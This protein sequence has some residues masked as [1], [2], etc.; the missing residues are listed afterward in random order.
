M[1]HCNHARWHKL[2]HHRLAYT[3]EC[4]LGSKQPHAIATMRQPI[5]LMNAIEAHRS[6]ECRALARG[7]A[8]TTLPNPKFAR[9][10]WVTRPTSRRGRCGCRS[11]RRFPTTTTATRASSRTCRSART[12]CAGLGAPPPRGPGAAGVA[13]PGAVAGPTRRWCC[14]YPGGKHADSAARSPGRCFPGSGSCPDQSLTS[15]V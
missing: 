7:A 2:S 15:T 8:A 4:A 12:R 14:A 9:R 3:Y 1:L 13:A 6:R 10:R 11:A 5:H